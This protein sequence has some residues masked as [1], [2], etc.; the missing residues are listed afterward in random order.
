[1]SLLQVFVEM[2]H[3]EVRVLVPEQPQHPLQFFLRRP[4]RRAPPHPSVD[5]PVIALRLVALGP[6]LKCPHADPQNL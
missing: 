1:M 5:K 4:P 2:L 6:T 3:R